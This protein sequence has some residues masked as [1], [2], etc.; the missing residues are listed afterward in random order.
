MEKF[1][2]WLKTNISNPISIAKAKVEEL[3]NFGKSLLSTQK[4]KTGEIILE[5]PQ[6]L[7]LSMENASN[8][9]VIKRR[10][11]NKNIYLDKKTIF[12]Y[13]L[14]IQKFFLKEQSFWYPYFE[15]LPNF[16]LNTILWTI[17]EIK[18]LKRKDLVEFL[19]LRKQWVEN[20]FNKL[21]EIILMDESL[22]IDEEP[23]L[24][25]IAIMFALIESRTLYY[26]SIFDK[27]SLVGTLVP[28]YDFCNHKFLDHINVFDH[29]YFDKLKKNYVLKAYKDLEENEQIFI[30]Y[31]NYN[32][33]HFLQLYGFLP[34]DNIFNNYITIH[35]KM[36]MKQIFKENSKVI[37]E[38]FEKKMEILKKNFPHFFKKTILKKN[39]N[40]LV[41]YFNIQIEEKNGK[42]GLCW[43]IECFFYI[44][45]LHD[46]NLSKKNVER[47]LFINDSDENTKIENNLNFKKLVHDFKQYLLCE[48]YPVEKSEFSPFKKTNEST[49]EL[50]MKYFEYEYNLIKSLE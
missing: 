4:I 41:E 29:F 7:F 10:I 2:K 3:P 18:L 45:S 19:I 42:V 1:E 38:C 5:I 20:E 9:E 25:D 27:E 24:K 46:E 48:F 21:K 11:L 30:C 26:Q 50:A 44:L 13:F 17:E 6:K 35:L 12:A 36:D 22:K 31:G 49:F 8:D 37:F 15:I 16:Y 43:E 34:K 14:W 23:K 28:Y 32:N 33:L 47:I 40:E 39:K